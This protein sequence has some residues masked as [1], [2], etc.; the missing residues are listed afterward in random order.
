MNKEYI[1]LNV[2]GGIGKNIM[3]T[4]VLEPLKKKFPDLKIIVVASWPEIFMYSPHVH[5]VY[6]L[7]TTPYFYQDYIEKGNSL[8]MAQDPYLTNSYINR[9]KHF[10]ECLFDLC[11]LEYNGELPN[12]DVNFSFLESAFSNFKRADKKLMLIQ[13]NGGGTEDK[14]LS[15]SWARDIPKFITQEVVNKY[16]N[17]YNI[18]QI[19]KLENQVVDGV[20]AVLPGKLSYM[21]MICIAKVSDKRLLIDSCV[22]HAC[23]AWNLPSTV[24]WNA[25]S[26]KLLGYEIH[27]NIEPKISKIKSH[28]LPNSYLHPYEIWGA[29]LECPYTTN[30]LYD[31]DE[32]LN[33]LEKQ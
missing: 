2:S 32:I 1:V 7:G 18:V 30:D 29:P 19:C 12:L 8:V 16:K 5:K 6:R 17:D 23:A 22:Q 4:A 20:T 3:S 24:L 26:K 15:Y 21:D 28:K 11:D 14:K 9:D 31:I 13:S 10:I 33:S 25:T 27:T